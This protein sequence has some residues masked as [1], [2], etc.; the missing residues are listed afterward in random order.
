M[1]GFPAFYRR[2]EK[3]AR[4]SADGYNGSVQTS[5]RLLCTDAD[6]F[7]D[8]RQYS[9]A[10]ERWLAAWAQIPEPRS[11]WEGAAGILIAIGD[12]HLELE[13]DRKAYEVYC[14]VLEI[15]E[16][17]DQQQLRLRL[18][19]VCYEL[20]LL[21]RAGAEFAEMERLGEGGDAEWREPELDD[22]LESKFKLWPRLH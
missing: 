14:Q 17:R 20:D 9:Q 7:F 5:V 12:C 19:M 22:L 11:A 1:Q 6:R 21:D 2:I 4:M 8:Q 16:F 15:P 13:Q 18:G 3:G 10:L